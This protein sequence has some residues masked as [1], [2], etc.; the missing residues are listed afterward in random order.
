MPISYLLFTTLLLGGRDYLHFPDEKWSLG[1]RFTPR[2]TAL[3]SSKI[4]ES[5]GLGQS[6]RGRGR[7]G[8]GFVARADGEISGLQISF[9]WGQKAKEKH[10]LF[11]FFLS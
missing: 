11:F 2:C 1:S 3:F 5:V 9:C 4:V 8:M 7:E 6:G 10:S